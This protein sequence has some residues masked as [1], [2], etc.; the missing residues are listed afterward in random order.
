MC[1][2]SHP[3]S[4]SGSMCMEWHDMNPD[5]TTVGVG[6]GYLRHASGT[7]DLQTSPSIWSHRTNYGRLHS[8]QTEGTEKK[9][10]LIKF[11]FSLKLQKSN[12]YPCTGYGSV[13]YIFSLIQRYVDLLCVWE[14]KGSEFYDKRQG[15]LLKFF[16]LI[17]S[18]KTTPSISRC[19]FSLRYVRST[20]IVE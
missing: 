16:Y 4:R 11:L 15:V 17:Q 8:L 13:F 7:R 12:I 3:S 19:K 1:Q 18:N 5:D 9:W 6:W 20:N 10:K 14:K 2:V